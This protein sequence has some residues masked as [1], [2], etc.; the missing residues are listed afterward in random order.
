M[1][2][3]EE[4]NKRKN[5]V[6]DI[7]NIQRR[8]FGFLFPSQTF[9]QNR[10]RVM[11]RHMAFRS[12]KALWEFITK[13]KP[14]D[15]FIS[16]AYYENPSARKMGAKGWEGADLFFDLDGDPASDELTDVKGEAVVI[17]YAL[18]DDFDIDSQVI[19][20]GRK[21]YHVVSMTDDDKVL[22]MASD[23]RRAVVDYLKEKYKC[24]FIDEP[25]SGDVHRFRR[26]PGTTNSKSGKIC[27]ILR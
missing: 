23:A 6:P 1:R 10:K 3:E 17:R 14:L 26:L 15:C 16:S 24:R 2:E 18:K 11:R 9:Q 7:P 27:K 13:R 25:S 19:F 21:G 4:Q 20:S 8:E 5:T 22:T 12:D